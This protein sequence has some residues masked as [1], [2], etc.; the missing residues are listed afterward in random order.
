VIYKGKIVKEAGPELVEVLEDKGYGWIIDEVE[1][2]EG[3]A[4]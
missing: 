3:A 2:R 1:G 4:A